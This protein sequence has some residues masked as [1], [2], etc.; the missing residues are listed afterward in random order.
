LVA[1]LEFTVTAPAVESELRADEVSPSKQE[2][3]LIDLAEAVMPPDDLVPSAEATSPSCVAR[4]TLLDDGALLIVWSAAQET[5]GNF[6]AD[7]ELETPASCAQGPGSSDRDGIKAAV[8]GRLQDRGFY[9]FYLQRWYDRSGVRGLL[10]LEEVVAAF[11]EA[12]LSEDGFLGEEHILC[13]LQSQDSKFL[14]AKYI[15]FSAFQLLD[16]VV[17]HSAAAREHGFSD[18]SRP[19]GEPE[20]DEPE[21][22]EPEPVAAAREGNFYELL[23]VSRTATQ[24]EIKKA[25]HAKLRATHPDRN[26][27]DTFDKATEKTRKLY[28]AWHHLGDE[29]SRRKYDLHLVRTTSQASPR[30]ERASQP[31]P[32]RPTTSQASPADTQAEV[33]PW[34]LVFVV[35][36]LVLYLLSLIFQLMIQYMK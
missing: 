19:D 32:P 12:D 17:Q 22:D 9:S 13:W 1:F 6:S 35:A 14:E 29:D 23:G 10:A 27:V 33:P 25:Y 2:A 15:K 28:D 21:P 30:P 31:S 7:P 20:P 11:P 16:H 24:P 4:E 3:P 34:P 36:L 8:T 26:N 5:A 18:D